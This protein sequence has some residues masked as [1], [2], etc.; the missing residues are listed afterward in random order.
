MTCYVG[1]GDS[2]Y[3]GDYI[4]MNGTKLWDG[5]TAGG[6]SKSNPTN[7][8]NST[9][10]GASTYDGIDIDT[11]GIDPTNGQYITWASNILL[12]GDTSAQVDIITYIDVWNVVYM[13][14]S[15][16]SVTTTGGLSVT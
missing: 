3:S 16:R 2:W 10:M 4:A 7:V 9:S 5:T 14:L 12:P 6:N 11:L 15:F 13:I 8:F 1:E